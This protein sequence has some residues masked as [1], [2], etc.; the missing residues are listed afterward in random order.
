MTS[1]PTLP[2]GRCALH[3]GRDLA[4]CDHGTLVTGVTMKAR[5]DMPEAFHVQV[6]LSDGTVRD[7][8]GDLTSA[9]RF[10]ESYRP[11]SQGADDRTSKA[12]NRAADEVARLLNPG[13]VETSGTIADSDAVNLIVNLTGHFA[14]HPDA[15]LDQAIVASYTDIDID[16]EASDT[17]TCKRCGEAIAVSESGYWEADNLAGIAVTGEIAR[18]TCVPGGVAEPADD[19]IPADLTGPA[20]DAAIVETVKGWLS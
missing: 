9:Y 7:F 15:T 20:R 3:G 17:G 16:P 5:A 18:R 10:I 19:H 4:A 13:G 6:Q 2:A 14:R 11:P 8:H 12:A 1:T